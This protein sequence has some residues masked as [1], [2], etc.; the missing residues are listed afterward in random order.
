ML[1]AP[2]LNALDMHRAFEVIEIVGLLPPALLRVDFAGVAAVGLGT[3]ALT[4]HIA[5]VG[6]ENPLAVLTVILLY[7]MCHEPESPQGVR[8]KLTPAIRGRLGFHRVFQAASRKQIENVQ[9]LSK[10][11]K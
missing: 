11:E 9:N 1:P 6:M 8:L 5:V 10:L 2:L 3:E 7:G 4:G